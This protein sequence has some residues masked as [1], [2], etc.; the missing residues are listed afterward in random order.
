VNSSLPVYPRQP[1]KE[2]G[3]W[4]D[5]QV[6]WPF[7]SR[8]TIKDSGEPFSSCLLCWAALV[9]WIPS[10]AP[11]NKRTGQRSRAR[12]REFASQVSGQITEVRGRADNNMFTRTG[13]ALR[14]SILRFFSGGVD[15]R[16]GAA[17]ARKPPDLAG[18]AKG[19]RSAGRL[20]KPSPPTTP[21]QQAK[22]IAG[23]A[24]RP[25]GA[26]DAQPSSRSRKEDINLKRTQVCAGPPP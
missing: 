11:W 1:L 13:R 24:S 21:E 16:Q 8:K 2:K 7:A 26:L 12:S 20:S 3:R 23:S 4:S 17:A 22:Y 19:R 6:V 10:H 5:A 14:S 15:H 9:I 25:G 18:Q